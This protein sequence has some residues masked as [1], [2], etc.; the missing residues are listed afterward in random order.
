MDITRFLYELGGLGNGAI[1][2]ISTAASLISIIGVF[3]KKHT[4]KKDDKKDYNTG[5][6]WKTIGLVALAVT[7]GLVALVT[8]VGQ[9]LVEVP[10]V[11]GYLYEDARH[12]LVDSNLK[13]SVLVD[14]GIYVK[15][16]EPEAG[17]IVA[18]G[19]TVKLTVSQTSCSEEA[20]T[21]F[22]SEI[23]A[24]DF[25]NLSVRFYEALVK[26][27]DGAETLRC[28]GPDFSDFTVA[29]AYLLQNDYGVK[30]CDYS[31]EDGLL[32]F[33]DIP[34]GVEF[35]LYILLDGYEETKCDGI[36]L[37]SVNMVDKTFQLH[38]GLMKDNLEYMPSASFRVV[39]SEGHFLENVDLLIKWS[40][41]D[42]WYGDYSSN[43]D[44]SFPYVFWLDEN[45][46]LDVCV[47]DP[48][49]DGVEYNCTVTLRK[50]QVGHIVN[51]DIIIVS[52]NGSCKV[53]D[54]ETYF[55]H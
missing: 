22:E 16:Q 47:V 27:V 41:S 10:D 25:G 48:L 5:H 46:S 7:F 45:L 29:E 20:I 35:T 43:E 21:Y 30:Y 55:M 2:W 9:N 4:D 14:N 3:V 1:T 38:L 26:V 36:M 6:A 18:P 53:V 37:S 51:D 49:G 8:Y 12:M 15:E 23:N 19:T 31:I 54:E 33:K 42:I 40:W 34:T 44:G 13:Y 32:T 52:K 28:F 24:T 39:D 17:T 11:K 50:Y